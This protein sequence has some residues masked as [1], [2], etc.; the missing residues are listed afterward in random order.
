MK[1][2][3]IFIVFGLLTS[4]LLM[5]CGMQAAE[6]RDIDEDTDKCEIC[7]MSVMDNQFATQLLTTEGKTYVFDDIGCMYSWMKVNPDETDISFVRDYKTEDWIQS[8]DAYYV[9]DK[10]VKTPMAYNVISF[11]K[12]EDAE[13]YIKENEGELLD[14]KELKKHEWKMNRDMMYGHEE[15]HSHDEEHAE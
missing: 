3:M 14:S 4:G 13:S 6:P 15:G 8:E 7:S 12:K 10:N 2:M 9:Y 11:E 1:K 5:G